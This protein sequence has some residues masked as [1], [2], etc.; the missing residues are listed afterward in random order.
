VIG[1]GLL[2]EKGNTCAHL[3]T[4]QLGLTAQLHILHR[5][6]VEEQVC[7]FVLLL[8]IDDDEAK[9]FRVPFA[10]PR[11]V[12]TLDYASEALGA[13]FGKARGRHRISQA[14]RFER[15]TAGEP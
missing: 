14:P 2:D 8:A 3:E 11:L 15:D 10:W 6:S 9:T 4:K 1:H 7:G 13:F 5:I 12:P